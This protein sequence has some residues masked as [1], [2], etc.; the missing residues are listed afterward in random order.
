MTNI[1]EEQ[2]EKQLSRLPSLD[3]SLT[4]TSLDSSLTPASLDSSLTPTSELE[5]QLQ[6]QVIN[7]YNGNQKKKILFLTSFK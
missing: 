6:C 1:T 5:H 4:P 2:L 7:V 3:S